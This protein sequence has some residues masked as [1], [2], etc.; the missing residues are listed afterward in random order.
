MAA[1][2][3]ETPAAVGDEPKGPLSR[4]LNQSAQVQDKVERAA[5][6]LSSVNAVLKNEIRPG[7]A[8][9]QIELALDQSEAVE[10]AVHE[11]ADELAVINDALAE[12]IDQRHDLERRL[13]HSHVSLTESRAQERRSRHDALHDASTGLP[14]MTLFNDRVTNAL[15]Q[16]ERHGRRLAVLFMDLDEFKSVNDTHGHHVGD[17]VLQL[18]AQRLESSLRGGDTVSRRGGDEF[19]VLMLDIKDA[20]DAAVS[21]ARIVES[22]GERCDIDGVALTVKISVGIAIYPDDGHSA[23]ELTKNADRAMYAAKKRQTGALLYSELR[24]V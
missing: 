14:N 16:A 5:A 3:P 11:A 13:S 24:A 22:V 23:Q 7:V 4:A 9:A 6:D 10:E 21:A 15:A 12:E 20:M 17:R 1:Q 19:L 8:V 2:V 18:V